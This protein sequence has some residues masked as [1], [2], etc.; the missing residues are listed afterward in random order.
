MEYLTHTNLT[1]ALIEDAD[2]CRV[3]LTG[4]RTKILYEGDDKDEAKDIYD[5]VVAHYDERKEAQGKPDVLVPG[6]GVVPAE[7]LVEFKIHKPR[8][9]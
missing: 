9:Q 4:D 5:E 2:G 1:L 7:A 6:R 8:K 3:T